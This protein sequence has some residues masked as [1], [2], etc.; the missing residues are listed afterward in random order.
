MRWYTFGY[1]QFISTSIVGTKTYYGK[2]TVYKSPIFKANVARINT[3]FYEVMK[4]TTDR[5][6]LFR[7]YKDSYDV[8]M[9]GM[10]ALHA[11]IL[12]N[13]DYEPY[14]TTIERM[15]SLQTPLNANE[16][17]RIASSLP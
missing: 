8:F 5:E 16:A 4:T 10:T 17:I 6:T 9:L 11:V 12:Y 3:E 14:K 13:L 7:R 15:T 1:N 2:S